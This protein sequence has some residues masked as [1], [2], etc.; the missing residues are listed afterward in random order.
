MEIICVTIGLLISILLFILIL[1]IL[2]RFSDSSLIKILTSSY[3]ANSADKIVGRIPKMNNITIT[4]DELA[5]LRNKIEE[6]HKVI[7]DDIAKAL[8]NGNKDSYN[9][10]KTLQLQCEAQIRLIKYI[11]GELKGS[12]FIC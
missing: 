7:C 9:H 12:Y 2:L 8:G 11:T 10:L 4:P 3:N 6:R 1:E 5:E